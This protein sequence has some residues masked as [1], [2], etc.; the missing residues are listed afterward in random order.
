VYCPA[1]EHRW[2]R[3]HAQG[4]TPFVASSETLRIY[5]GARDASN[6]TSTVFLDARLNDPET[7][8]RVHDEPVLPLGNLGCFD[9]AGV[10]PSC[11]VPV[12]GE[13]Y[14]YYT[15]WN[16]STTVP[17]RN[18]I[19][20]AASDDGGLTFRRP[21][22]G[23]ILDRMPTEPHFCATPFVMR[24]AGSWRMWYLSCSQWT[25]VDGKP[26][27]RYHIR[28]TESDDGL[29]WRRPGTVAIDYL[30][31][32]EAIARPWVIKDS[33][34]YQMWYCYRSI[35]GYRVDPAQ[36]Y[37]LGFATSKDGLAWKRRDDVPQLVGASNGWDADMVAYPALIDAGERRLLFYNGNGFGQTGFGLAELT[38]TAD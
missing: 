6:R 36:A 21:F 32:D 10:M 33:S 35:R 8:L 25:L 17:Y 18:S 3:S 37:Q 38:R 9:D 16:T 29:S 7:I 23:P 24:D 20:V 2:I 26:E 12:G 34:G 27:A 14:L 19:G 22:E 30:G 11:I 15:G 13:H 31:P 1:G 5:F 4:P 28:H